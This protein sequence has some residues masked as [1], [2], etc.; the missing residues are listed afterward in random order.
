M[1]MVVILEGS[2]SS[3]NDSA[4]AMPSAENMFGQASKNFLISK[5]E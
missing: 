4:I 3:K 1:P 5:E 2:I